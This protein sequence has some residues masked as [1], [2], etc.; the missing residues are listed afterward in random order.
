MFCD[1]GEGYRPDFN[2]IKVIEAEPVVYSYWI[3]H[4]DCGV[5]RCANCD[6][7][8][9]EAWYSKYCPN[10]GANMEKIY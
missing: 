1:T 5:T 9:E 6:W 4:P 3:H 8:I 2:T 10:C 7:S